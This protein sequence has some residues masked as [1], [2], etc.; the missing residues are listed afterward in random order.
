MLT[1][2][3]TGLSAAEINALPK[4][5]I[6]CAIGVVDGEPEVPEAMTTLG[7]LIITPHIGGR[8]PKAVQATAALVIE[9]LRAAPAIHALTKTS[10]R[11]RAGY[12]LRNSAG[13]ARQNTARPKPH[14]A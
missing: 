9:N 12:S 13:S 11:S 5:E 4:L 2:G 1:N 14:T 3:A 10:G 8:A 7:N 6:I